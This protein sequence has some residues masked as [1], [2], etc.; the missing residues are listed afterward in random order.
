MA[1]H[2]IPVAYDNRFAK[3]KLLVEWPADRAE[4]RAGTHHAR[5]YGDMQDIGIRG[6]G[7]RQEEDVRIGQE[8]VQHMRQGTSCRI[9]STAS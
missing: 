1:D 7:A 6:V 4:I 5:E 2:A 9:R 8:A 3:L